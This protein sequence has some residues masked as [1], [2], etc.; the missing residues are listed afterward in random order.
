M[1]A[2]L[3][4]GLPWRWFTLTVLLQR[5]LLIPPNRSHKR[6]WHFCRRFFPCRLGRRWSFQTWTRPTTTFSLTP[7]P[8]DSISAA[9]VRKN[10]QFLQCFLMFLG[11]SHFD[12]IF[13]NI[14]AD[15][16]SS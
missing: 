8:S 4:P 6:I 9:I 7:P 12:A 3:R 1:V 15:L 5:R 10:G 14:C 2:F 13:T 16:F 11:W